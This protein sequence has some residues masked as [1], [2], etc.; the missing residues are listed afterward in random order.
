MYNGAK[1]TGAEM[2]KVMNT[3]ELLMQCIELFPEAERHVSE[4]VTLGE[5][6]GLAEALKG[7]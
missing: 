7:K 6:M 2:G 5:L 3:I 4:Y 1:L